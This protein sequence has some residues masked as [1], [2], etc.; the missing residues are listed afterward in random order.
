MRFTPC[1]DQCTYDGTHCQ[2][3]GRSR[4]EIAGT[5][6]LIAS[7]V[8]FI[9]AQEYENSDEFIEMVGKKVR[10]KLSQTT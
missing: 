10:K 5:K 7:F 3:C 9:K 1:A 4:E 8:E 2:G 6:K